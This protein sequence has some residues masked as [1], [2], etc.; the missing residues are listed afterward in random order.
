[1]GDKI[2]ALEYEAYRMVSVGIPIRVLEGLGG[3]AI[4]DEVSVGVAVESAYYVE[5]GG[6]SASRL[7]EDRYEFALAELDADTSER[8]N[9]TVSRNIILRYVC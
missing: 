7:T 4:Y 9:G 8:F 2:I 6:F 3:F 5:K 1:M